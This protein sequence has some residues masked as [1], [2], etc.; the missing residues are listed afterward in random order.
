MRHPDGRKLTPVEK[1]GAYLALEEMQRW[2]M[3]I[4]RAGRDLH[5]KHGETVSVPLNRLME[6]T[7][8]TVSDLARAAK[9]SIEA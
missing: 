2:G 9:A 4:Q 6:H 7:G 3:M 1:R 5:T 8:R